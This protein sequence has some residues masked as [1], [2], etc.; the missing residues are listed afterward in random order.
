M[1]RLLILGVSPLPFETTDRSFGPGTRTW[2]ITEP[3]LDDGHEVHLVAMRI[4]KTY[5]DDAPPEIVRQ[6]GRL[7]YA[8]VTDELY[9]RSSYVREVYAE[10]SPDAVVFAHG[11]ASFDDGLLDPEVPIWIDLCGHVMAEAQAKAA[12]YHDDSY[13]EYFLDRVM[14]VVFRGDRF[15]TVSD[16]QKWALIGE[17]G[18]AGR[19]NSMT[20]GHNLVHTIPCG[21]EERD[22]RHERTVLRGV[23]VER[24]AFVVLWSGGF[25][26]WTDVD[27]MFN[28]L[29]HAMERDGS[30]RFVA[31]GGQIDGHDE[32][33]YPRFVEMV[34]SSPH[35]NRFVLKG[36]LPKD[37]VPNYYFEANVGI[38]CE[39]DIYEVRLGS[40]HRILDWS[41]AALPV[42][43]TRVTEL[44]LALEREGVGFV[45]APG[46][47]TALGE[48]ILEA[49]RRREELPELGQ[50]FRQTLRRLYGFA[51]ST[52]ELRQWAA[53]P[54]FA[55]DRDLP[56]LCLEA[57]LRA[58][59][60]GGE[61][62]RPAPASPDSGMVPPRATEFVEPVPPVVSQATVV[63]PSED[64]LSGIR[65]L[66]PSLPY[67]DGSEE[68]ILGILEVAADRSSRSDELAAH[69]RDWPS[70]YHL[71][72]HRGC[73]LEPFSIGPGQRVLEVGA[74]MGAVSR[75]LGETGAEV[76]ALEGSLARARAA[77]MRCA[78]LA[79]VEVVCGSLEQLSD[80]DGFDLVVAV[81]VLEYAAAV[82]GG[83]SSPERF[84]ERAGSFLRP[85]GAL[86]LATENQ[87]GLKY[88]LGY[89]EDHLGVPWA[90]LEGY[91][92]RPGVETFTRRRLQRLLEAAGLP[93]QRWF[94][95]FPDYKLPAVIL[96]E[97]AYAAGPGPVLVDQLVRGPV[98]SLDEERHR[99]CDDR[100]VHRV[101]LE[102][103]LGPDVA[104]SFL[105]LAAAGEPG[106]ARLV[107]PARLVWGFGGERRRTWIR[108]QVVERRTGAGLQVRGFSGSGVE[109]ERTCG[110]LHQEPD[111]DEEYFLGPTCEQLALEACHR[112]RFPELQQALQ[113]WRAYLAELETPRRE[114]LG[115][116][117]PFLA[118]GSD[119]LLPPHFLDVSLSNFVA[120]DDRLE[121]IDQEWHAL[122][123]VEASLAMTRSLWYFA[124]DLVTSGAAHPW[125]D[126]VRVDEL[127]CNLGQLCGL[128]IDP[129][130]LVS[131]RRAEAALQRL[132][133]GSE[134][135]SFEDEYERLGAM[136]R[137]STPVAR[138]L[139][140]AN[141][142][143]QIG[144]QNEQL[145]AVKGTAERLGQELAVSRQ[146]AENMRRQLVDRLAELREARGFKAER[147]ELYERLSASE[148]QVKTLSAWRDAF[149]RRLVV[150]LLRALQGGPKPWHHV[151]AGRH[152]G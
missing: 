34:R 56:P 84:L 105:V 55:P 21:V 50:R 63:K 83:R 80:D 82:A 20:N 49:L 142:V 23:D 3:L 127:A 4:P 92:G 129:H 145:T 114:G 113:R 11:S 79:N 24:E 140:H 116:I 60:L 35:Q 77:A 100:A 70:R 95:P 110:W 46:D 135:T 93:A 66:G 119:R 118:H 143:R 131:F 144:R 150:R 38:N 85:G 9:Y 121:F 30:I 101:F 64:P 76:V 107:D 106:V 15:S 67:E 117:H 97:D 78:G 47:P 27:T 17:L 57:W 58:R 109:L 71:S 42:V 65:V 136:S 54:T 74:G 90:G 133:S 148:A 122:E 141:L 102:E 152:R 14:G 69:I 51:E 10:L 53:S 149:E 29:V 18:L 99:L 130:L 26:T 68:R 134:V 2:Q 88:L 111:K 43:S 91:P 81:G 48:A 19:L 132:V 33:T 52:R 31:T 6:D 41:R 5:P 16:A 96:A 89:D 13:L 151:A 12:V 32:V 108:H 139:P 146:W 112:M 36:W 62:G 44:S 137:L 123:G 138:F 86:L 40:K 98:R 25:N 115:A 72:R 61:D 45:C 120:V 73:L 124:R 75:F 1:S 8:S 87:L 104:N 94:F 7:T 37:L 125:P 147:N 128:T 59:P 103:G 28:G 39:K 126:E 22:Y